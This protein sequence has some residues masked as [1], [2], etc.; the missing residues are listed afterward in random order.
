MNPAEAPSAYKPSI[1]PPNVAN[2]DPTIPK[3]T[4]TIKPAL[5]LPGCRARAIKP[6]KKPIIS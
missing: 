4:V 3:A 5:S 2:N 6:A 1:L